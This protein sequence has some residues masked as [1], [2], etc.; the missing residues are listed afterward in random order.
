MDLLIVTLGNDIGDLPIVA[1]VEQD[2]HRATADAPA[3]LRGIAGEPG[4]A[5]PE[6][7]DRWGVAL[8][9]ES[10]QTAHTR[11][12]PVGAHRE[13]GAHRVP[14]ILCPVQNAAHLAVFLD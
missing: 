10:S 9:L 12:A 11:E 4:D 3:G 1:A 6:H 8:R 5:E 7:I 2:K 14:A 13:P